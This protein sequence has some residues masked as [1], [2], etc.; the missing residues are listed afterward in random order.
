MD[1]QRFKAIIEERD[2]TDDEWDAGVEKCN[3]ALVSKE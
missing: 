1:I 2:K 3:Q